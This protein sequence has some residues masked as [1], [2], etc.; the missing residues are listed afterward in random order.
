MGSGLVSVA[1]SDKYW[2]KDSKAAACSVPHA[3]SL[4][5]RSVF[6][7]GRLRLADHNKSVQLLI[8]LSTI[9]CLGSTMVEP[10]PL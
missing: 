7:D 8:F 5:P 2:F 1:R 9:R 4:A 10:F 6:R 3:K